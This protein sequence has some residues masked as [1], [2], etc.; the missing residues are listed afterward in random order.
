M[1]RTCIACNGPLIVDE[2]DLDFYKR[3][4]PNIGGRTYDIPAPTHCPDC[5]QQ[6][7]LA[8]YNESYLYP[9]EC[10][11]CKKKLITQRPPTS[12]RITYC[13]ECWNGDKWDALQYGQDVDFSRPFLEQCAEVRDRTPEPA[14]YT[15][16]TLQNSEYVHC[17]DYMKNCYLVMHADNCEDCYYGYGFKHVRS[18]VDGFYNLNCEFCYDCIDCHKCYGLTGSQDCQNCS[19]SAFLRDCIGCKNCT[20]CVGLRNKEHCFEN[21]QL[22]KE[23]YGK[24]AK[25][26][27]SGSFETYK[28]A[29]ARRR[30]LER[31]HPFKEFQGHTLENC[32]G[33]HLYNC[34]DVHHSFDCENVEDA[35]YCYQ[36]VT[37]AKSISDIYQWGLNLQMSYECS[38][39]GDNSYGILFCTQTYL[40]SQNVL[41]SQY[42]QSCKDCFGCASLN[43]KKFCILNKQYTKEEYEALVPKIVEHMKRTGE[44]GEFFPMRLSST[45]YNKSVAQLYYPLSKNEAVARGLPWEDYE[46]PPSNVEKVI[47]AA[48]LPD[49]IRDVPDDVL[50]WAIRCEVT[51]K[52]FRI[53]AQ[54]LAFY[55]ERGIPLP[56]RDWLQRH[57]DRFALRNPRKFFDRSCGKCKKAIRTTYAPDRPEIVYC[58]ECYRKEVY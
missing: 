49:N 3:V 23:E 18:C 51:E 54:E 9:G 35:R 15:G 1:N 32:S 27:A 14:L 42:M 50:N 36:V 10:Q 26:Y 8:T 16:P 19:D 11:L 37:G 57:L 58:E 38:H 53:T 25:E 48:Q 52:P 40:S 29:K 5:R 33:N 30:E 24:R 44:W 22:S 2:T 4:S 31:K 20:L 17:A 34:K 41:Y 39:A 56:R 7:R 55:R 13:R 43:R 45:G 12:P 21:E 28:K 47:D 46:P 6:R